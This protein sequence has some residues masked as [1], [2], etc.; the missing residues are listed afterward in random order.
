M[1]PLEDESGLQVSTY[2]VV[3][4]AVGVKRDIDRKF[5]RHIKHSVLLPYYEELT[6]ELDA[7]FDHIKHGL[8][9]AVLVN[10]QRPAL[11][12]FVFALKT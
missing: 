2:V 3:D 12:N 8:V 1:R 10:E 7:R 11:R 4:S 6:C 9:T 5:G